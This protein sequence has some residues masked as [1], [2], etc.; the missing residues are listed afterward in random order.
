MEIARAIANV[1][2]WDCTS[3]EYMHDCLEDLKYV[4]Q[5][6]KMDALVVETFGRRIEK[7]LRSVFVPSLFLRIFTYN[8]L[9]FQK[10]PI[11]I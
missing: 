11:Q 8:F 1:N 6:R 4:I 9:W 5:E 2:N 7:L 10:M 3:L